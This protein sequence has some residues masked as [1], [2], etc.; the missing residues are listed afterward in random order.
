MTVEPVGCSVNTL[1]ASIRFDFPIRRNLAHADE[2]KPAAKKPAKKRSQDI[3]L[4]NIP[5]SLTK[6]QYSVEF[7]QA[8]VDRVLKG[9]E[10]ADQVAADIGVNGS[11]VAKWVRLVKEGKPLRA[12]GG[13]F[14]KGSKQP[15]GQQ[16]IAA[17]L[18]AALETAVKARDERLEAAATIVEFDLGDKGTAAAIRKHKRTPTA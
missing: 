17:G 9:G 6:K 1:A 2:E 16:N 4:A 18:R 10:V 11:M 5:E 7:K 15:G 8:A 3:P 13:N 14:V 12:R